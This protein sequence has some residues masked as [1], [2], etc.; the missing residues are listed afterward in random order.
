[1]KLYEI[2]DN[3]WTLGIIHNINLPVLFLFVTLD[4]PP[5]PRLWDT[6]HGYDAAI[7]GLETSL[8]KLKVDYLDLYLIHS[9]NTGLNPAN[10]FGVLNVVDFL[11]FQQKLTQESLWKHGMP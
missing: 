3:Y 5:F 4:P 8:K 7:Q 11:G 9:P 6:D 10:G 1:M 2:V